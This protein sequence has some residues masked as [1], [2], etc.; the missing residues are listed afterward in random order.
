MPSWQNPC[1]QRA[2]QEKQRCCTVLNTSSVPWPRAWALITFLQQLCKAFSAQS[3]FCT[4]STVCS[5]QRQTGP[6]QLSLATQTKQP[7]VF[8]LRVS[9][10]VCLERHPSDISLQTF[11]CCD[12]TVRNGQS[13]DG[14]TGQLVEVPAAKLDGLI[15]GTHNRRR[16]LSHEL[17]MCRSLPAPASEMSV[18]K[19]K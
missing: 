12:Y 3:P 17:H 1:L 19:R 9:M 16:K 14:E 2:A 13:R 5:W 7:C 15:T 8:C 10:P 18:K 11:S 6:G 4:D